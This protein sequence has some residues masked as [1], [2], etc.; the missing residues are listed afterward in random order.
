[1]SPRDVL[2]LLVALTA[3]I[4]AARWISAWRARPKRVGYDDPLRQIEADFPPAQRDEAKALVESIV[5]HAQ[6]D[7][8]EIIRRRVVD[9]ARGDIGRLRRSAPK[10]KEALDRVYR[11]L[12]D[13]RAET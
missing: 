1:V 9:A 12:G 7:D 5:A 2:L 8:R 4:A 13:G 10:A 11:L 3:A 6:P